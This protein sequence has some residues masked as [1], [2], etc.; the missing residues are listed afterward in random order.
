MTDQTLNETETEK[1]EIVKHSTAA[2]M[3]LRELAM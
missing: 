1:K 2:S 3:H